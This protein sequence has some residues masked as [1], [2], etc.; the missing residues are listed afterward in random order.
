M[1]VFG[2]RGGGL[3]IWCKGW[4]YSGS[5]L[6]LSFQSHLSLLTENGRNSSWYILLMFYC[7]HLIWI[8]FFSL[9]LWKQYSQCSQKCCFREVEMEHYL[10]I[11]LKN[12][13]SIVL[14]LGSQRRLPI[15][16]L[17]L[18]WMW[19]FQKRKKNPLVLLKGRSDF[20]GFFC[21]FVFLLTEE[22]WSCRSLLCR[23]G[24]LLTRIFGD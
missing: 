8:P 11:K 2:V 23:N 12:L 4:S 1:V 10:S 13:S 5:L 15:Y 17:R 21:L 22:F 16:L 24:D 3:I 14:V 9:L 18:T 7:V 20:S 19:S 6:N